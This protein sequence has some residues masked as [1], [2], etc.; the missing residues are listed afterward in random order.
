MTDE[1]PHAGAR[2]DMCQFADDRLS[3]AHKLG[4]VHQLLQ[5]PTGRGAA[6]TSTASSA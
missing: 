4:F 3:D 1:D 5:R 2:H 6:A